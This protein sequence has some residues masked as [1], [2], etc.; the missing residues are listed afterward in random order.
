MNFCVAKA[1]VVHC[2]LPAANHIGNRVLNLVPPL[3]CSQTS[4]L[5]AAFA[6]AEN[7][8]GI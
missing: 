1:A 5:A 4:R 7:K 2:W 8:N 3:S 6:H